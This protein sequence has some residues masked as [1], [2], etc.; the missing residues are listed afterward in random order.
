[1]CR[2]GVTALSGGNTA[3][4]AATKLFDTAERE[5]PTAAV[6][7]LFEGIYYR[8]PRN[9][10]CEAL[11]P[12]GLLYLVSEVC[13]ETFRNKDSARNERRKGWIQFFAHVIDI[14]PGRNY[15]LAHGRLRFSLKLSSS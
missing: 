3:M 14:D 2:L 12:R 5:P 11:L 13:Q 7:L 15:I 9:A 8:P 6:G 4:E 10:I 1:M